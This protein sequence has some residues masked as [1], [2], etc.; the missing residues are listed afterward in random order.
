MIVCV[1]VG[2]WAVADMG[3]VRPPRDV[4]IVDVVSA[5]S[6]V[7]GVRGLY[8]CGGVLVEVVSLLQCVSLK[9][10]CWVVLILFGLNWE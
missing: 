4:V 5:W 8:C 9:D 1:G 6:Y 3:V 10:L 7:I 2:W